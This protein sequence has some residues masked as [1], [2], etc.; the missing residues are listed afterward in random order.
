[1]IPVLGPESSESEVTPYLLPLR[2]SCRKQQ[3]GCYHAEGW[4]DWAGRSQLVEIGWRKG[5]GV[6]CQ[7][8]L[9]D[10]L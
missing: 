4:L 7:G 6:E 5:H 1:M 10:S 9:F 3:S 2:D 8:E